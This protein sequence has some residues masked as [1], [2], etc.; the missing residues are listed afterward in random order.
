MK[1]TIF[2][3]TSATGKH[4]VKKALPAGDE[5][6]AFVRDVSKLALTPE[7]LKVVCGDALNP[8]QVENA[9]KGSDA[10]LSTL[11][12]KGKPAVMVAERTRNIVS[13]TEKHGVKR[14]VQSFLWQAFAKYESDTH[15]RR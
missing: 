12:P 10:V 3:A 15:R 13:V 11:G 1:L 4:L 5:V 6:N 14:L 2:G 7:C 9:V 8:A